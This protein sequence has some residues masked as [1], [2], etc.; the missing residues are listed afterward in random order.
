MSTHA[1]PLTDY[2]PQ[3]EFLDGS[4]RRHFRRVPYSGAL[5]ETDEMELASE[6][7]EVAND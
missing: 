7:L 2:S 5:N 6:F 3:M 1:N 4:T